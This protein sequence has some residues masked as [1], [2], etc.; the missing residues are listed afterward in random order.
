MGICL[1][2][3]TAML[4]FGMIFANSNF[5]TIKL[6]TIKKYFLQVIAHIKTFTSANLHLN[7]K[8]TGL[9]FLQS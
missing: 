8:L 1:Y 5:H 6:A 7:T 3:P 9:N 4:N 2:T